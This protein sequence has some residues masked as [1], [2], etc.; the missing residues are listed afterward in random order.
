MQFWILYFIAYTIPINDDVVFE[1]L[2]REKNYQLYSVRFS[3]PIRFTNPTFSQLKEQ[4]KPYTICSNFET[5]YYDSCTVD[6]Y[7]RFIYDKVNYG[8]VVEPFFRLGKVRGWPYIKWDN[9]I[10]GAFS[11]AYFFYDKHP[12]VFCTG[13]NRIHI[14]LGALLAEEDPPI[15]MLLLSYKNEYFNFYYF[16]GQLDPRITSDSTHFYKRGELKNRYL[17]GHSLELKGKNFSFSLTELVI[18]FTNTNIPDPYFSNPFTLYYSKHFDEREYGEHNACWLLSCNFWNTRFSSH[19]EFLIDDFHLPDNKMWAPHKLAWIYK[20]YVVDCP[21]KNSISGVSYT[22]A[23][24]WTYTHGLNLLYYNN[25]GEVMGSLNEND[26]D[27][28]E[29]FT[30][31]HLS[32]RFDLKSS[33]WFKRKGEASTEE[34]D[35]YWDYLEENINYPREYFLTGIVEKR[36]GSG[37]EFDYHT[38]R[39]VIRSTLEYDWICNYK[40]IQG[41]KG[42]ELRL[43]L[44]GSAGIF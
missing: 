12:F 22:G 10:A 30:R 17:S 2:I 27:R 16:T 15:D 7:P 13:R 19:F 43:K 31:K 25:R 32:K 1:K 8:L 39:I 26:F 36:F 28:I 3:E 42:N 9:K 41:N 35:I 6:F 11:R 23:T 34:K 5:F 29:I 24:R 18:Y 4:C 33:F 40:H 21:F 38:P 20:L 14:N 37:I 44:Y